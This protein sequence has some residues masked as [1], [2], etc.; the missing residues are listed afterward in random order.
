GNYELFY[1]DGTPEGTLSGYATG[2]S[3]AVRFNGI[4]DGK[5]DSIR[6][7]FS[8]AGRIKLD[9]SKFDGTNFL[10][11][12]ALMTPKS[13]YITESTNWKTTVLTND[14]I[15]ASSNFV[16][17]Y[18]L[19]A[20]PDEP[21]ITVSQE[22]DDGSANSFSYRESSDD[23]VRYTGVGDTIWKYMIR[24]YVSVGGTTVAIDQ[25]GVVTIPNEFSLE[26]N[27][28]NPFNPSTTFRF[29]TPEDGLVKF[30]VHDLL[31]R[32]VYS[33]NRNLFAGN[34]SFTWDGQNELNQQ[35][36][37]SVYFLRMEADGFAQTRKM[38]MMK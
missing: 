19:G 15:D 23:W 28:P 1:D 35:V 6:T 8:G 14:N 12:E 2:D 20:D 7:I 34:Y 16:V 22:P 13:V 21:C 27:Y 11:G 36:V 5:L 29:S 38:L 4:A 26:Q 9:I 30:T 25:N 10:R 32:V 18:L 33:E 3:I 17:S 24:A 37:S 31:G